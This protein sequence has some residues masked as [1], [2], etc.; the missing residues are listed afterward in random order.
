MKR[1][2]FISFIL[3]YVVAKQ[4]AQN[5]IQNHSFEIF[6]SI[7]CGGGGFDIIQ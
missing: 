5:L 2:V 1:L 4:R 3:F 7:D 6:D